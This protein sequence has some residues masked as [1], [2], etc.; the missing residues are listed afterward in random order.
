MKY[1]SVYAIAYNVN[2]KGSILCLM[3]DG[4]MKIVYC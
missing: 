1:E 2:E 4:G 3:K